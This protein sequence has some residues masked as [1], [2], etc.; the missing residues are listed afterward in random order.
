MPSED[1]AVSVEMDSRKFMRTIERW[2]A[3]TPPFRVCL[4]TAIL[5]LLIFNE[6]ASVVNVLAEEFEVSPSAVI[7]WAQGT[8]S[9][10]L[11]LQKRVVAALHRELEIALTPS[12]HL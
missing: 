10:H 8:A 5:H 3:E 7:R 12:R 6:S 9:P 2:D 1:T 11:L 4:L